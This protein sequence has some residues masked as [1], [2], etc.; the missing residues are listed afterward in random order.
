M[1]EVKTLPW[2]DNSGDF[3]SFSADVWS[4]TQ[5]ITVSTPENF[6]MQRGLNVIFYST[7]NAAR[8]A[9]LALKQLAATIS[10]NPTSLSF[11]A[12]AS[13][14]GSAQTVTLNTNMSAITG[15][16][17]MRLT[18]ANASNF[19]FTDPSEVSGGQ[20]TFTVY[21]N[22]VWNGSGSATATLEIT[23]GRLNVY[24][25]PVTQSGDYITRTDYT[26]W[27]GGSITI[28]GVGSTSSNRIGAAG[29]NVSYTITAPSRTKTV[30]WSSG[31]TDTSQETAS[32][33]SVTISNTYGSNTRT[34]SSFPYNG[35][36]SISGLGT[37]VRDT[38]S[39]SVSYSYSGV[40]QGSDTLYHASNTRV[41]TS[42]FSSIVAPGVWI[43]G[44]QSGST[45]SGQSRAYGT[46]T[47]SS[48]ASQ[49]ENIP[50]VFFIFEGEEWVNI[51][52]QTASPYGLTLAYSTYDVVALSDNPSNTYSRAARIR[53]NSLLDGTLVADGYVQQI[54]R[55][56][57]HFY[58]NPRAMYYVQYPAPAAGTTFNITVTITNP[59]A[60]WT[61]TPRDSWLTLSH[62]S[63]TDS[64]VIQATV[65][66]N[67]TTSA[68]TTAIDIVTDADLYD[69]DDVGLALQQQA[70]VTPTLSLSPTRQAVV[71][72]NG[73]S[74]NL[75]VISNQSWTLTPS[76]GISL[77][78]SS[79]SG[80]ASVTVTVA[81][82]GALPTNRGYGD[83]IHRTI[84]A[85]AG[86]L[87]STCNVF[88]GE[89][90]SINIIDHEFTGGQNNPVTI[91]YV[92]NCMWAWT[93]AADAPDVG[94]ASPD[95][96]F[97]TNNGNIT[98]TPIGAG[99]T[100]NNI[101]RMIQTSDSVNGTLA[102]ASHSFSY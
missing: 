6:G 32:S 4:G 82:M 64:S 67:T 97:A 39:T 44:W 19:S 36:L 100:R 62:T 47:Y 49:T 28:N 3:I 72:R 5:T 7:L 98:L 91:Q 74:F 40:A 84:T 45:A 26:S 43:E 10:T 81:G 70:A 59:P 16:I 41:S 25:L 12:S 52:S 102:T 73:G 65:A 83:A 21:P 80:N 35:T 8:S 85:N 24:K 69:Y 99:W 68:R 88:V 63:G 71:S 23:L 75:T 96:G 22:G 86:G 18:G 38:S 14:A 30:H 17:S 77:S 87:S 55:E 42:N 46:V 89:T 92:S 57:S 66:R 31:R 60:N 78:S 1:A 34:V 33:G 56:S 93:T 48:G 58:M 54:A 2:Q 13:G 90:P 51:T 37:T 76:S 29:G 27:S 20:T 11:S 15:R 50:L 61:L 95:E 9:T 101:F 53:A 94:S 79:G